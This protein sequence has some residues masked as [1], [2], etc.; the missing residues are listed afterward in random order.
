MNVENKA[1]AP[2]TFGLLEGAITSMTKSDILAIFGLKTNI[3]G[4]AST[5]YYS[6]SKAVLQQMPS[7]SLFVVDVLTALF[8]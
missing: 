1:I 7:H 3:W 8:V 5:F 2:L 4:Y 6:F